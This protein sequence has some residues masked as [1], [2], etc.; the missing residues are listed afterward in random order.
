[1]LL[2]PLLV[3]VPVLGVAGVLRAG[4]YIEPPAAVGGRWSVRADGPASAGSSCGPRLETIARS[5][6]TIS[7]SGPHV[8][9]DVGE[10]RAFAGLLSGDSIA[11]LAAA[12]A[13][14]VGSCLGGG[15]LRLDAVVDRSVLPERM[16]AV[17]SVQRCAACAAVR[18]TATRLATGEER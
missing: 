8:S 15:A 7:Q 4:A 11:A 14:A 13:D 10:G 16:H 3:G 2:Y 17:L 5:G 9:V 18:F 6:I 1:L 12:P